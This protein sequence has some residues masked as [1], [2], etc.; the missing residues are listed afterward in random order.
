VQ[1][2]RVAGQVLPKYPGDEQVGFPPELGNRKPAERVEKGARRRRPR[3]PAERAIDNPKGSVELP[4]L[5]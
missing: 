1:R 2:I 4:G 3:N 5:M